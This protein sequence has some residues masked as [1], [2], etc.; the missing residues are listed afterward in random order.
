MVW[1]PRVV[2]AGLACVMRASHAERDI[3]TFTDEFLEPL[4]SALQLPQLDVEDL[5]EVFTLR[6]EVVIPSMLE[7]VMVSIEHYALAFRRNTADWDRARP[8]SGF[9]L[10]VAARPVSRVAR[11][12]RARGRVA[13]SLL[14][15]RGGART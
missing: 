6:T 15:A 10:G 8:A 13:R 7:P 1:W 9:R 11:V 4:V 2:V 12:A 3:Q 14:Q 5:V